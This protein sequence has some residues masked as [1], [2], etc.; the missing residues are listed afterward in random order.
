MYILHSTV[1]P[2]TYY[3]SNKKQDNN[4]HKSQSTGY[5]SVVYGSGKRSQ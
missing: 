3:R 1:Y 5:S 4:A 2:C